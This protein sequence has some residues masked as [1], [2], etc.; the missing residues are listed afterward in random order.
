MNLSWGL[1][2][3]WEA[4]S[5]IVF[6]A[7]LQKPSREHPVQRVQEQEQCELFG[8]IQIFQSPGTRSSSPAVLCI[9]IRRRSSLS[10][11]LLFPHL[12]LPSQAREGDVSHALPQ[13][14]PSPERPHRGLHQQ[15][16]P[17]TA[18]RVP[19]ECIWDHSR[20]PFGLQSRESCQGTEVCPACP[21][22]VAVAGSDS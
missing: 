19:G 18:H 4:T 17:V 20:V 21:V 12:V 10:F 13:Q 16:H 5:N 2:C 6:M 22:Q 8:S 1:Q 9:S 7:V 11:I 3:W 15:M 14:S